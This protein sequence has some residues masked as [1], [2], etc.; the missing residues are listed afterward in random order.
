MFVLTPS[1]AEAKWKGQV[2]WPQGVQREWTLSTFI[3]IFEQNGYQVTENRNIEVGKQKAAIYV[4]VNTMEPS[5]FSISDGKT[6]KSKLGK[7][8]DIEAR[9]P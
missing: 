5:H 2:F 4:D 6:W 7:L 3:K 8:Q 9:L 1:D